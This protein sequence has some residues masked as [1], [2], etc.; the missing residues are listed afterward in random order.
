MTESLIRDN[1]PDSVVTDIERL[2]YETLYD[3]ITK[4]GVLMQ[5]HHRH[6]LAELAVT[7]CEII[8]LRAD[9]RVNGNSMTV[10]GDKGNQVTKRNPARDALEKL[11][12]VSLRL[13]KEFK[14]TPGSTV[15]KITGPESGAQDDGWNEV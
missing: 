7:L 4:N 14:M 2:K 13:M 5:F 3:D 6:A 10:N 15:G 11:R 12:P 9:I 8:D 1:P